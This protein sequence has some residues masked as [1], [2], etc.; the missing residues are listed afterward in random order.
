MNENKIGSE[1]EDEE[2]ED[3]RISKEEYEASAWR[4]R[5][6]LT[7]ELM[8]AIQFEMAMP[9]MFYEKSPA[10]REAL[11]QRFLAL[12]DQIGA[13]AAALMIRFELAN[14]QP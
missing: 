7:P 4:G 2:E 9:S 6:K 12:R 5:Q 10:E 11:W 8:A 1:N 3:F 14:G 13:D